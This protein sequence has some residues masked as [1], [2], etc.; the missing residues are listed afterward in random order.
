MP[1]PKHTVQPVKLSQV[2]VP[3]GVDNELEFVVNST[4]CNVM[5]QIASISR[6]ANNMFEE[7]T[8][9]LSR[10]VERTARLQNRLGKLHEDMQMARNGDEDLTAGVQ[11]VELPVFTSKKPTDSQVLNRNTIPP[12]MQSHYDQ[13]EPAPALQQM[14]ALRDDKKISMKLYSDP[15]FFFDLWSQEMLQDPK[16]KRT[17]K[18]K[19]PKVKAKSTVKNTSNH[20]AVQKPQLVIQQPGVGGF[21]NSNDNNSSSMH[22]QNTSL[23][24]NLQMMVDRDNA[25][26]LYGKP[27]GQLQFPN[28]NN[29][30]NFGNVP[31]PPPPPP[32]PPHPVVAQSMQV[33]DGVD[34]RGDYQSG[35]Q[36]Y[37]GNNQ[38]SVI[39]SHINGSHDPTSNHQVTLPEPPPTLPVQIPTPHTIPPPLPPPAFMNECDLKNAGGFN[40][41]S[42]ANSDNSC[43]DI[44]S[45]NGSCALSSSMHSQDTQMRQSQYGNG[46]DIM[47]SSSLMLNDLPPPPAPIFADKNL[48]ESSHPHNSGDINES[49][50]TGPLPPPAAPVSFPSPQ[51]SLPSPPVQSPQAPV[52]PPP[53]PPPPPL[54]PFM[55]PQKSTSEVTREH[56]I[57]VPANKDTAT[58]C[59]VMPQCPP[60]DLLSAIR[61]GFQLRKVGERNPPD[62]SKSSR[63]NSLSTLGSKPKDVQAIYEAVRRRRECMENSSDEDDDKDANSD[64]SGWED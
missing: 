2:V 7:L 36:V 13:A 5:R 10:L 54:P 63:A 25:A 35:R 48:Y 12:S 34:K 50:Q 45:Q 11:E 30:A 40:K 62:P 51:T 53:P 47:E 19:R 37:D 6:L 41:N 22:D 44:S 27:P 3:N 29:N 18:K 26:I 28:N 9:D 56:Q 52:P 39:N 17:A 14:D 60:Q 46:G 23:N 4:V 31:L 61:A 59:A 64:S 21:N 32:P 42:F 58:R 55:V 57:S 15:S 24:A 43:R 38:F 16:H 49:E 8:N 20:Q 33:E 1:L